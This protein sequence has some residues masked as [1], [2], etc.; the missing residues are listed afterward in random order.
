MSP[1]LHAFVFTAAENPSYLA[2]VYLVLCKNVPALATSNKNKT[3]ETEAS[4]STVAF[5]L[6]CFESPSLIYFFPLRRSFLLL[7]LVTD[8]AIAGELQRH[9]LV[10]RIF[11]FLFF[12]N[13]ENERITISDTQQSGGEKRRCVRSVQLEIDRL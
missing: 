11:P 7:S 5:V 9:A 10:S 4:L 8:S 13:G 6:P 2:S 3:R 12:P 1:S